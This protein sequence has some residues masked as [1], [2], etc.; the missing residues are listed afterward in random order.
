M[1]S[2]EESRAVKEWGKERRTERLKQIEKGS[3]VQY[4]V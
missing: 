1:P 3:A 4:R 2:Y